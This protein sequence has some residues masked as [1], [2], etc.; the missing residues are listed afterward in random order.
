MACPLALIISSQN[1]YHCC[2]DLSEACSILS[3]ND[4]LM[5]WGSLEY[6]A[7]SLSNLQAAMHRT[8]K[9]CAIAVD[10]SGRETV[11]SGKPYNHDV[12]A[13]TKRLI[14]YPKD[15]VGSCTHASESYFPA[16]EHAF[17]PFIGN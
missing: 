5:Q 13:Y 3:E 15:K 17:A 6:H 8:Q 12:P 7:Q 16:F 2:H 11:V 4:V 1:V 14:A 10:I 9:L